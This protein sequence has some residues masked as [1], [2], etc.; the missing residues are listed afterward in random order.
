MAQRWEYSL[1]LVSRAYVFSTTMDL[2]ASINKSAANGWELAH[3]I[4]DRDRCLFI[5]RRPAT[6]TEGAS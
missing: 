6:N 4:P 5:W 3:V 1:D 2:D